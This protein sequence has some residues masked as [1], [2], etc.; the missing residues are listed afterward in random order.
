MP[1]KPERPNL[2]RTLSATA[3]TLSSKDTSINKHAMRDLTVSSSKLL[4]M[5]STASSPRV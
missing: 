4:T 2:F 1:Y 3:I 5:S